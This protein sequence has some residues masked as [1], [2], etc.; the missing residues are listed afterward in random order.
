[1]SSN[2]WKDLERKVAR[3]LGGRRKLRGANFGQAADDDVSVKDFPN[4]RI[5]CKAY[6]HF[7]HHTLMREIAQK[8]CKKGDD[9][10]V[11]V[12]KHEGQKGEYVTIP[13]EFFAHLL[14]QMRK[15]L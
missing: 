3:V 10:P 9:V 1:M 5:D 2:R 14:N 4:L 15:G 6:K 13:L 12:T 7:G 11:L 8:Y